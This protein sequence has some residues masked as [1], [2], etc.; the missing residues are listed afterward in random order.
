MSITS[1]VSTSLLLCLA[2]PGVASAQGESSVQERP[3]VVLEHKSALG[4]RDV[5]LQWN[6]V[7][8]QAIREDRSP[9]P[10]A[11]RNLAIVH[12]AIFDAVNSIYG[13]HQP[14]LVEARAAPWTT[15]E[16][17]VTGAAYHA[18]VGLY[19]KQKRNLD[20]TL[21][22]ALRDV[23][24]GPGRQAGF[25]LGQQVAQRYLEWRRGDG[26]EQAGKYDPR[27]HPGK[28]QP[29]SPAFQSALLPGWTEV[30]P[31]AIRKGKDGFKLAEPPALTSAEYTA[32]FNEVKALGEKNS[33]TRTP[34]QTQ[35][36]FFWADD[37]GTS[38]P[39]G[40]WNKIA[41][42]V[43][44][45]RGTTLAENARLFA[46]LN[47]GMAD[48]GV[49]CWIFKFTCELWR[50]ITG[51]QNAD[52]DG[53]PDTQ[54]DPSWQ[55]LLNTPPFPAFTSGHSTFSSAA[56]TVLAKFF[57]SD[58]VRFETTSEGLP[59][60]K[61]SFERFS[62]AA[63]EAGQSRI[64]GGI[65]WQFDNYHGL[66]TGQILGDYVCQGFLQPRKAR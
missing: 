32:A 48:A 59:G 40:H 24:E 47:I 58:A 15:P 34:E 57:G 3:P 17:A 41:Q 33:R 60:V 30:R 5:V 4:K 66:A 8:L 2:M 38:T 9:P 55:P 51:I 29:T 12:L 37:V 23:P 19:P 16:A 64:Y 42:D 21:L 43:A 65:H 44:H 1:R 11:A 35:I 36:A 50:P 52:Q 14:Y 25:E 49:L 62:A 45:Q 6:E 27:P 7:T 26:A 54:A 22:D 18:L 28:W 13:T 56:A 39:P 53:N 31:F 63:A 20:R 10:L 46:L 61:R